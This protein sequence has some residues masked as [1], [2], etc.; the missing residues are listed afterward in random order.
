[1]T[2]PTPEQIDAVTRRF[3]QDGLIA[4]DEAVAHAH[5]VLR[6]TDADAQAALAANLPTDVML[7]ALTERGALHE[8]VTPSTRRL[9]TQWEVAP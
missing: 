5:V 4:W 1:M 9:V 3:W 8:E 6:M 2:S 7:A